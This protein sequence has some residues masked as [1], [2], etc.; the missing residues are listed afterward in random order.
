MYAFLSILIVIVCGFIILV[1]LIQNPKG[2]GLGATFAGVSN[3]LMGVQRTTD[4]LEKATWGFA[5]ALLVLSLM[6]SFF[7]PGEGV[8]DPQS[9]LKNKIDA[10]VPFEQQQ[11]Q[12]PQSQP[13]QGPADPGALGEP[14]EESTPT[15]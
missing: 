13:Q 1:V 6:T 5:I 2:G 4:F 3:N 7:L 9:A 12:S 14:V 15:E 11:P 8:N 10:P